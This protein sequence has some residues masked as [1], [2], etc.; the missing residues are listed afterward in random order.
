MKALTFRGGL[1]PDD[2]KF[3]TKD[4]SIVEIAA[5]KYMVYPLVQHIG[6]PCEPIVNVGDTVTIGQKIADSNAFV[7]APIHSSVSGVVTAIE[8]RRHPNGNM[9]QSIVIENDNKNTLCDTIYRRNDFEKL[10]KDKKIA[11]IREAGIVG[12][13]GAGFPAHIKLN[14]G[15]PIDCVIVNGA[16]CEPYLTSD[17]R[18]MLETP[19]LVVE[20]LRFIMGI[21][22]APKAYIAIE[23]NKEAA[24]KKMIEA[25]EKYNDIEV[26]T[27]KTKYPQGGEKQLIK[28]V[29]GREVPSGKLP[30]DVGVIVHNVDT[31]CAVYNAAMFRQPV[32]S[33][34]VTISGGAIDTPSNFR[35]KI[36]TAFEDIIANAGGL[37]GDVKKIVMGGPMMGIAQFDL[38]VPTIKSTSAILAFDASEIDVK[39]KSP[40][41][42]CGKCVDRCPMQLMPLYLNEFASKGDLEKCIE[43]GIMDCIECGVCS[44]TCQSDR[45]PVQSIKLAKQKINAMKKK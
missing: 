13:G 14:P 24:I 10:S 36:G 29:T 2:K 12:L 19:W 7:S 6:A 28:A 41:I 33:R 5:S 30:A 37:V 26:V 38:T 34:V 43:Y 16:E 18:V 4:K 27:L 32:L 11:V 23:D 3:Y 40:C 45:H 8:K 25:S 15:K 31:S 21:V 22:D 1:H 44:Y 20:G 17:Y 39:E 9:V 42:R 35:V